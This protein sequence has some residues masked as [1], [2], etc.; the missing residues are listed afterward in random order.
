[1]G[2]LYNTPSVQLRMRMGGTGDAG[3]IDYNL[4]HGTD[5]GESVC[6]DQVNLNIENTAQRTE[7]LDQHK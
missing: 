4:A 2:V 7:H 5:E 6:S 3:T 1:M